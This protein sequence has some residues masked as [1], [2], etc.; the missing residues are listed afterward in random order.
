MKYKQNS[1][2]AAALKAC[3][4]YCTLLSSALCA[5]TFSSPFNF[6]RFPNVPILP[7]TS[8]LR[9]ATIAHSEFNAS[10][11]AGEI[12]SN[13]NVFNGQPYYQI[14][15]IRLNARNILSW[16]FTLTYNGSSIRPTL[17]SS[18]EK[19]TAGL[20]GLGWSMSSPYVGVSHMGTVS[21][22][23][24]V[25]YCDLGPYGGGQI[26]QNSDGRFYLSSNPYIKISAVLDSTKL[27]RGKVQIVSWQ[28]VMPDGNRMFFGESE[29]SRRT[30]RSR[31]NVIAAHP[32][33][34]TQG[35][36]FIYKYD[37]SRFSNFDES[38]EIHFRYSQI[39]EPLTS[40]VSYVR[41]SALSAVYWQGPNGTVDSIALNYSALEPSEYTAYGMQESRDA[42][43]LYETRY[44][45]DIKYFMQGAC[46]EIILFRYAWLQSDVEDFKYLRELVE[47]NDSIVHGETRN[48]AFGYDLNVKMLGVVVRP[49]RSR[50]YFA[51]DTVDVRNFTSVR[52][53]IVPDTMRNASK[54]VVSTPYEKKDECQNLVT[55]TEEFCY[56]LLFTDL[57]SEKKNLYVQIYHN[58]GN[59]FSKPW[60]YEI[61][62]KKNPLILYSSDYFVLADYE[63]RYFE[64][65]EWNGFDFVKRNNDIG[66]FV[67]ESSLSLTGDIESVYLQPNYA[68]ILEKGKKDKR[69]I[70]IIVKDQVSGKWKTLNSGKNCGFANTSEYGET[71]RDTDSDHCLEWNDAVTVKTSPNLF[72]V[73]MSG[74]DVINVF[75][76]DGLNFIELS[77][78]RNIFPDFGIQKTYNSDLYTMNFQVEDILENMELWG[79]YLIITYKDGGKEHVNILYFDGSVFLP[80]AIDSWSYSNKYAPMEFYIQNSYILGVS[81]SISNV[82]LWRKKV[83]SSGLVFEKV[84]SSVFPFDGVNN[85]VYVSGTK[86]AF[87]L[88]EKYRNSSRRV[89]VHDGSRYYNRLMVVPS[90]PAKPVLEYTHELG[91]YTAGLKFSSSD[92]VVFYET[93]QKNNGELCVKKEN[94]IIDYCS[95]PRKYSGVDFFAAGE[96]VES[97][98]KVGSRWF[99]DAY[100]V[101]S[102]NRLM[103][104]SSID[105]AAGSNLIGLGQY[106]GHNFFA[107][108]TSIFVVS[109]QWK[110]H[111]LDLTNPYP[112][113]KFIYTSLTSVVEYNAHTQQLQFGNPL[114]SIKSTNGALMTSSR[115]NFIVD[116]M[117]NPL[118]G[119]RRN[120]QG[121]VQSLQNYDASG[122]ERSSKRVAY[123]IDS[124]KTMNWPNGLIV[125]RVDSTISSAVDYYGNTVV[126]VSK[127]VLLDSASGQFC[128]M[129]KWN[130][131]K[132]EF[133]QQIMQTVNIN[134]GG[135][136]YSFRNPSEMYNY[137]P[138]D[139]NPVF[140]INA[141]NPDDI[142]FP[143]SVSSASKIH[144]YGNKPHVPNANYRWQPNV[145]NGVGYDPYQGYVLSDSIVS[146]NAYG[147][148]TERKNLSASGMR[149]NCI[150]YEG[151]RSLPT[152]SFTGAACSDVAASTAEHG[153]LNGWEMPQTM[154]DSNQVFDGLYSFRVRDGFGPTRNIS[155]K[156]INRYKYDYIVSAYGYSTGHNPVL[157]VELRRGDGS[158]R[159][160]FASYAP[161]NE[162]FTAKKWQRY[163]V[164]IPYDSLVA[165]GMFADSAS[166]DYLRIWF[167][168]GS[169][170][171]DQT[172]LMYVDNFVAYPTSSSFSLQ[173]YDSMGLQLSSTDAQFERREY[174]YDKNH[175]QR[176]VRDS[177]GRIYS[178]NAKHMLLENFED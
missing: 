55:C 38:T 118:I 142:I 36:D 163:E 146:L 152:A 63:S 124:G 159:T 44:L 172:R 147:Q 107:P 24:D 97:S 130:G 20:Y 128:G 86:D 17:Q 76:F 66:G 50:E 90:D 22:I 59:Y 114:V 29:N 5:S 132:Y 165:G 53:S 8:P 177:K 26:V 102:P 96:F 7:G 149:S 109:K 95:R 154:L 168:F 126:S 127:N 40:N 84:D 119:Y 162:S 133:S 104:A 30:Q 111:G 83:D 42:Q 106:S 23:D 10:Q 68:L 48:W 49:D 54:N 110:S 171:N 131:D 67:A 160:V 1:F 117:D 65:Y 41:E 88:E 58:N 115:Y 69:Y 57:K 153:S 100:K 129:V 155:L 27:L 112:Y 105:S 45:S 164:E 140:A 37:L 80:M 6:I 166:S 60:N 70:H 143:D 92:P 89:A 108:D 25:I 101:S 175:K 98:L 14:P 144:Y 64:F 78:N 136:T 99:N 157:A 13:V 82:I 174:V 145:R 56:G 3:F 87:Y 125:N 39:K 158:I 74:R 2:F 150:V 137:V 91:R 178:D 19:A 51:Y 16:N 15:L 73:G 176:T 46:T 161:V 121:S 61:T 28:F 151:V 77:S 71:I 156:E 116:A 35:D 33:T 103:M 139:F 167:G 94:C 32:S 123:V 79:N 81:K 21:T 11:Q 47:I 52:S 9:S 93:N 34:V 18:N 62:E 43:K 148:V 170:T 12:V 141:A 72:V 75:S 4:A 85:D 113:T 138:F 122:V 173:S 169:P 134:H 120:L 135:E 31:G